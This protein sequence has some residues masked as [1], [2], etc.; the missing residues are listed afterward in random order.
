MKEQLSPLPEVATVFSTNSDKVLSNYI[1]D[2]AEFVLD[3]NL[4]NKIKDFCTRNKISV[5]NF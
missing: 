5:Y 1:A 3:N 4:I 2:R